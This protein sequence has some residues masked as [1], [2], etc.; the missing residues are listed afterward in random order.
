MA[1]SS[2]ELVIGLIHPP[3]PL[4]LLVRKHCQFPVDQT[5]ERHFGSRL[6]LLWWCVEWTGWMNEKV[7]KARKFKLENTVKYIGKTTEI[8]NGFRW[9]L[10]RLLFFTYHLFG[11]LC[12]LRGEAISCRNDA[13]VG[14]L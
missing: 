7:S 10:K 5:V 2:A 12:L 9:V 1:T 13:W 8:N 6:L 4:E 14:E 3:R 11:C